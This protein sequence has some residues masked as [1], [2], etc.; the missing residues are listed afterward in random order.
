MSRLRGLLIQRRSN[1]VY[2]R[3]ETVVLK[4]VSS[5]M[6]DGTKVEAIPL[7]NDGSST[8]PSKDKLGRIQTIIV[9]ALAIA[10]V[11]RASHHKSHYENHKN[12]WNWDY[13][14]YNHNHTQSLL[15]WQQAGASPQQWAYA[16]ICSRPNRAYARQWKRDF[17]YGSGDVTTLLR[18]YHAVAVLSDVDH[19]AHRKT[20]RDFHVHESR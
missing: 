14:M 18:H 2:Q 6:E 9:A 3:I 16:N 1:F 5:R 7:M 20:R 8:P 4:F 19:H 10:G 13:N 17:A 12:S 11:V 15:L